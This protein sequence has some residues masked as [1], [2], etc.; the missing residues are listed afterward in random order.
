MMMFKPRPRGFPLP[1]SP[2]KIFEAPEIVCDPKLKIIDW[3][4]QC[5]PFVQNSK[6]ALALQDQV[7]LIDHLT[8]QNKVLLTL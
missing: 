4:P 6:L 5:N 2:L 1:T 3:S 8:G 7:F